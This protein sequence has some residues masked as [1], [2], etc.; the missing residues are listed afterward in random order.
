LKST[1]LWTTNRDDRYGSGRTDQVQRNDCRRY[2]QQV[3]IF[4]IT[5]LSGRQT[6]KPSYVFRSQPEVVSSDNVQTGFET[7]GEETSQ[8]NLKFCGIFPNWVLWNLTLGQEW[9]ETTWQINAKFKF[10]AN[11]QR[12]QIK[13]IRTKPREKSAPRRLKR[14][15]KKKKH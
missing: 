1:A 10:K 12:K 6:D 9:D 4:E 3:S 8:P 11:K 15:A 13:Q 14:Y 5:D 2:A 7:N